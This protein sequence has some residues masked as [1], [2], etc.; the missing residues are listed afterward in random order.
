[1]AFP[2]AVVSEYAAKEGKFW[3]FLKAVTSGDPTKP[4]MTPQEVAQ[5]AASVGLDGL[6]AEKLI[7][8][9]GP[10]QPEFDRVYQDLADANRFGLTGTPTYF[11][12]VDGG[13][14]KKVEGAALEREFDSGEFAGYVR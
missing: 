13:A 7:A 10:K 14:P 6:K 4:P 9:M 5:I 8:D 2:A 1:M 11:V 12:V 3:E